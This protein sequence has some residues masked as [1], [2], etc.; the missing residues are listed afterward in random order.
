MVL[1]FL[2]L[3]IGAANSPNGRGSVIDIAVMDKVMGVVVMVAKDSKNV[4]SVS[5]CMYLFV[6][7]FEDGK[8]CV[9]N[10]S[11]RVDCAP[12]QG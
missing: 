8:L 7:M 5:E 1:C 9:V 10:Q 3:Q 4:S 2:V 12:P 11:S 6:W